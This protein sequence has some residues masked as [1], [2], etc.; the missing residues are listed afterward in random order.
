M[1]KYYPIYTDQD[2]FQGK[3]I[4]IINNNR[5]LVEPLINALAQN[6]AVVVYFSDSRSALK[7]FIKHIF[8]LLIRFEHTIK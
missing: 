1:E 4:G 8:L 6:K 7:Y 5:K 3:R 2:I